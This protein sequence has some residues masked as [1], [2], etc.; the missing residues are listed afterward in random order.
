MVALSLRSRGA[1][2]AAVGAARP[3]WTPSGP[4]GSPARS[5]R[6]LPGWR[7][8]PVAC[9]LHPRVSAVLRLLLLGCVVSSA[10]PLNVAVFAV[11]CTREAPGAAF[12]VLLLNCWSGVVQCPR[13]G[14]CRRSCCVP[15]RVVFLRQA[16]EEE[17]LLVSEFART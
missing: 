8:R 14:P 10:L 16:L 4:A 17:P 11:C 5:V 12:A 2:A 9:C 7:S 13:R 15:V 3:S 1:A 6:D